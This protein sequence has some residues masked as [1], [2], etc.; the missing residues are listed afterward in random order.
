MLLSRSED[1]NCYGDLKERGDACGGD[2]DSG[3]SGHCAVERNVGKKVYA[4][5]AMRRAMRARLATR[6]NGHSSRQ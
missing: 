5:L 2:R 3:V 6:G 4:V 1:R